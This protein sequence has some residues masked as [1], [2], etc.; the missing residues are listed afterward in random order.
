MTTRIP[1]LW[2]CTTFI[3]TLWHE[4][5]VFKVPVQHR[6]I[7][8]GSSRRP[9]SGKIVVACAFKLF[10]AWWNPHKARRA[11]DILFPDEPRIAGGCGCFVIKAALH[12]RD[13]LDKLSELRGWVM[14]EYAI[15][16]TNTFEE[17]GRDTSAISEAR[18][19][20]SLRR[21]GREDS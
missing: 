21:G 9:N 10:P 8:L 14:A 16:P 5:R 20:R 13:A 18:A 3:Q 11:H 7:P 12:H 19:I 1:Q 2:P 15:V 17:H 4:R 6:G